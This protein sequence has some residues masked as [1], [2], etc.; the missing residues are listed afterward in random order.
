MSGVGEALGSAIEIGAQ[1]VELA[2]KTFMADYRPG[3]RV[4]RATWQQRQGSGDIIG[5]SHVQPPEAAASTPKRTH[6]AVLAQSTPPVAAPQPAAAAASSS[7]VPSSFYSAIEAPQ[8]SLP[9]REPLMSSVELLTDVAASPTGHRSSKS[10]SH[11]L[12][13]D[14]SSD[15]TGSFSQP[16][17]VVYAAE[18]S[19]YRDDQPV[20][21]AVAPSLLT[22]P[23]TP[24]PGE[25]PGTSG[26]SAVY[27]L[28]AM[29][30]A[31]MGMPPQL[32]SRH[33][34]D[35]QPSVDVRGMVAQSSS[36]L[37]DKIIRDSYDGRKDFLEI[38]AS[39]QAEI[40][41]ARHLL[42]AEGAAAVLS[43]IGRRGNLSV[44]VDVLQALSGV[45]FPR[46]P[47]STELDWLV[48]LCPVLLQL[49]QSNYEE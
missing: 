13:F 30:E 7:G 49:L 20:R 11:S 45:G 15:A 31:M 1:W 39:R 43:H 16:A 37:I 34:V 8:R 47:A 19:A 35:Q 22:S 10:T 46:W 14:H 41:V 29:H 26:H 9:A 48:D 3:K 23:R 5:W 38:I 4:G 33:D 27:S 36:R 12:T 2:R 32:P 28:Q 21:V 18:A 6:P 25:R 24:M 40:S 42:V 17:P 44:A